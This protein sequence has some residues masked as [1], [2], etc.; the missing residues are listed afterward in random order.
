MLSMFVIAFLPRSKHLVISWLWLLS[1]VI[2]EPRKI[3]SATVSISPP[4]IYHEM[5]RQDTMIL[6]FWMVRFKPGFSLSSFTF[7][8]RLF[9]SSSL[10]AIRVIPSAYLL[11]IKGPLTEYYARELVDTPRSSLPEKVVRP[12]PRRLI[13][14]N[15]NQ[16]RKNWFEVNMP[17]SPTIFYPVI[18]LS[19]NLWEGVVSKSDILPSLPWPGTEL[20]FH[21]TLHHANQKRN[22]ATQSNRDLYLKCYTRKTSV[23]REDW[24][25]R[26]WMGWCQ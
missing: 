13:A 1:T 19:R 12:C 21:Q 11:Y 7:I 10:S 20:Y 22:E 14:F 9:S 26:E 4:S 24:V 5:M 3:K 17:M 23:R 25:Q 8:R 16:L 18:S 2:L 15:G 6:A